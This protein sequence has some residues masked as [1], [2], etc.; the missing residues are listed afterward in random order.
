M[1]PF[2]KFPS[3]CLSYCSVRQPMF[4]STW[5]SWLLFLVQ[6]QNACATNSTNR[7]A[8]HNNMC[9]T[10]IEWGEIHWSWIT[11]NWWAI[12]YTINLKNYH[13][14]T[15][16]IKEL[17]LGQEATIILSYTQMVLI[18]ICSAQIPNTPWNQFVV[19][20]ICKRIVFA[21]HHVVFYLYLPSKVMYE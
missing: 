18:H 12:L 11:W 2:I 5:Q 6:I 13:Y 3:R 10:Q 15:A 9:W 20:P 4:A 17:S 8:C 16:F 1:R 19:P 21:R 7:T 14:G